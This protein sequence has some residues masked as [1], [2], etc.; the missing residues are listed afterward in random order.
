M[1]FIIFLC[2]K[3]PVFVFFVVRGYQLS[4]SFESFP[5]FRYHEIKRFYARFLLL[6]AGFLR[7][8]SAG[9]IQ[10]KYPKVAKI[11]AKIAGKDSIVIIS[12]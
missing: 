5:V 4:I 3:L 2:K 12:A 11:F 1:I 8:K 9:Q 10:Q 7:T 6:N